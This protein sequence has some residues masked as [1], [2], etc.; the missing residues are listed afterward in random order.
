M[1]NASKG[2]C[3]TVTPRGNPILD[4]RLPIWIAA[5]ERYQSLDR[6]LQFANQGGLGKRRPVAG[7]AAG[8]REL[9]VLKN[10]VDASEQFVGP[11]GL[12]NRTCQAAGQHT[13][14]ALLGLRKKTGTEKCDDVRINAAQALKGFLAIHKGHGKIEQDKIEPVRL[15][16]ETLQAFEARLDGGHFKP[17]LGKDAVR[18]DPGCRLVIHDENAAWPGRLGPARSFGFSRRVWRGIVVHR[19]WI[20]RASARFRIR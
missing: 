15:F 9:D 3:V 10:G 20:G 14:N 16:P 2:R 19:F 8:P 5:L 11:M 4:F 13:L 17:G 6:K 18:Q 12:A 1:N 7:G